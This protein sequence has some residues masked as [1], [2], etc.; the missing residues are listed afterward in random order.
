M[1]EN[2]RSRKG[3]LF[4]SLLSRAEALGQDCSSKRGQR[5]S[6]LISGWPSVYTAGYF[7]NP[8]WN[9]PQELERNYASFL[10]QSSV[11]I[12]LYC[13][14]FS[15]VQD[16]G[17]YVKEY[18]H[19][20]LKKKNSST[21]P[22]PFGW[23]WRKLLR[24]MPPASLPEPAPPQVLSPGSTLFFIALSVPGLQH[25]SICSLS[26]LLSRFPAPLGQTLHPGLCPTP[27]TPRGV[28]QSPNMHCEVSYI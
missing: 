22:E 28:W 18:F 19:I 14:D 24:E 26:V 13:R 7:V 25:M 2:R 27:K 21:C 10:L 5:K 3:K 17:Y 16:L 1:A 4:P 23:W 8:Q 11:F 15:W 12:I 9:L 6:T 20:L